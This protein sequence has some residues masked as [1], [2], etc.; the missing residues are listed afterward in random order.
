MTF[1]RTETPPWGGSSCRQ[2]GSV[3]LGSH[4]DYDGRHGQCT[5]EL[6]GEDLAMIISLDVMPGNERVVGNDTSEML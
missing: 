5:N 1:L 2:F 6:I 4:R 3:R